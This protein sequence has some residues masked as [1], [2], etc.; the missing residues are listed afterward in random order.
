MAG[1]TRL[2]SV[3][4]GHDPRDFVLVVFGGAGP[5][6]G[7]AVMREVGVRRMLIPP[8]PGVLCALGCAIADIRHDVSQTVERRT[9]DLEPAW[10]T[11]VLR[12]QCREATELAAGHASIDRIIVTHSAEMSYMGQIYALRIPVE[13]DWALDQ[14]IESFRQS[15]S[16][17]YGA[18][19]EDIP[20][21]MVS[22]RT[23]VMGVRANAARPIAERLVPAR[24]VR[25]ATRQ[26][27]FDGW[28]ETSVYD[29]D[30]LR[31]GMTF[32]GPAIVEQDD[33]TSVIEPR[34]RAE[35]DGFRNIVVEAT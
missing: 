23:T 18:T 16:R 3:E 28:L 19:L 10:V 34:M 33:T 8:N 6:H 30:A 24:A 12:S 21:M 5:L 2:L 17:E 31:P 14:M 13:I 11:Q 26:A 7:A 4:Q 20:V 32:E 15:Y 29:R 22:L 9:L 35:I 1:R 27:Y 25:S